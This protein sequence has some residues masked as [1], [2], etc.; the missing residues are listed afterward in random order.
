MESRKVAWR[1]YLQGSNGETHFLSFNDPLPHQFFLRLGEI[2]FTM[3]ILVKWTKRRDKIIC[4][5]FRVH[6][7]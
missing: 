2:L 7:I 5:N 3:R 4:C 6:I 1:M